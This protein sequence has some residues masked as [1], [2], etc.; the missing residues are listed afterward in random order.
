MENVLFFAHDPELV[1]M[2]FG[3]V[4]ELVRCTPVYRLTFVPDQRVWELIA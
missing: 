2:V 4:C 1:S 3:S